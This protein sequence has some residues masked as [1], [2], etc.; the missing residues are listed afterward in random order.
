MNVDEAI[1]TRVSIKEF[2]GRGVP[3]PVIERL[4]DLAVLAPNHRMTEPVEFLVLGPEA[5]RA[6]A[7]ALAARKARDVRDATAADAVREKVV[8]ERMAVPAMIGVVMELNENPEIREE[9][10]ATAFMSV[11]NLCLAALEEGLGTHIK[12]GA[13]MDDPAVRDALGIPEG[14]RL[15]AVVF[16]GEPAAQRAPKPRAP[17]ADRTRWLD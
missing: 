1:R 11:Q 5:R 2:E 6:Y 16:L 12:T 17:A 8:R 3:R 10:Y 13:V 14:S 15:V 7:E 4:L 9:D